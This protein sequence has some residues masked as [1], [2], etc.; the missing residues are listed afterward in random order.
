ML[1]IK[2][3]PSNT[4][5]DE[6]VIAVTLWLMTR[7]QQ[8]RSKETARLVEKY[9]TWLGGYSDR[10]TLVQTCEKLRVEWHA[11]SGCGHPRVDYH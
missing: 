6:S 7:Y 5:S 1:F 8:T 11:I 4:I 10:P 2:Q 9:L 3:Y